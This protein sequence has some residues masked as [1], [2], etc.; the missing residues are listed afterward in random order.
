[1]KY[2][3]AIK[4]E[5]LAL[6]N[7][8][9]FKSSQLDYNA[10]EQI[11]IELRTVPVSEKYK[12]HEFVKEFLDEV[13]RLGLG[14]NNIRIE[15]FPN[16]KIEDE[17]TTSEL[18]NQREESVE[19]NTILE[20]N[21]EK[22][23]IT[24]TFIKFD[25]LF[26]KL[27]LALKDY[28]EF[29]KGYHVLK[30]QNDPTKKFKLI[31]LYDLNYYFVLL[32]KKINQD[33]DNVEFIKIEDFSSEID[34]EVNYLCVVLLNTKPNDNDGLKILVENLSNII[35]SFDDFDNYSFYK[36][37]KGEINYKKSNVTD[38]FFDEVETVNK[39]FLSNTDLSFAE[40][41][42][43]KKLCSVNTPLILYKVLTKGYSG[44]K[45][46]EVRPKVS[47]NFDVERKFIIK[48][49]LLEK[50]K[51]KQEYDNF[52]LY[53]SSL[54][55]FKDYTG[56]YAKTLTHEGIKYNYAISDYSEESY[57]FNDVIKNSYNIF[58]STKKE[59]ID[60][61]FSIKLFEEWKNEHF[62]SKTDLVKNIF[63][64]FINQDKIINELKNILSLDDDEIFKNELIINFNKIWKFE[65]KYKEKIC[66]GDLHT[67]NFFIDN[68]DVF[69][70]DFGLTGKHHSLI[71]YTALECSLKFKHFPRF[72]ESNEL[73]KIEEELILDSTF[74]VNHNFSCTKR[75]DV[76][77]I[78]LMINTI[79]SNSIKDFYDGSN[80]DYFISLFVM[81]FRQITYP[82]MNQLYA[83]H[84]ANILS[85]HIVNQ[86]GI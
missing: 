73:I 39:S 33:F 81:T 43:I 56:E 11:S 4:R 51:L 66:H 38:D 15:D 85:K 57:S 17:I 14:E 72:L 21:N 37:K 75:N 77:D 16:N 40:E 24:E 74:N 27:Q 46:L 23:E 42:M 50:K 59:K 82:N 29:F 83:Y 3:E 45:V 55:G 60:K 25:D 49:D 44:A 58:Y 62:E 69:L 63:S 30:L 36:N 1:M 67:D 26:S 6:L 54:K 47:P 32:K 20:V 34:Y 86:L 84:S 78:L 48:Y 35:K 12:F 71:D 9:A 64:G 31:F 8:K 19:E 41:K 2:N 22:I 79:R 61:L 13:F 68:N 5:L 28:F 7:E 10:I 70:I 53:V 80:L 76:S 18:D 65:I 52:T